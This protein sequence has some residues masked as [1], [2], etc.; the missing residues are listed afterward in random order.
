MANYVA[1]HFSWFKGHQIKN[2]YD[3]HQS[4]SVKVTNFFQNFTRSYNFEALI[5]V[6]PEL[7]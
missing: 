2:N 1:Y 3:T 4:E 5:F 6:Q 7:Y